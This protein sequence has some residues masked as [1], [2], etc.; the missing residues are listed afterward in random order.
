MRTQGLDRTASDRPLG[1]RDT[2][3]RVNVPACARADDTTGSGS[4][5]TTRNSLSE[6]QIPVVGV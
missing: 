4:Q 2:R 3:E 5:S 6:N 1:R